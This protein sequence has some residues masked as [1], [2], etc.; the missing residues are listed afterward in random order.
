MH[1]VQLLNFISSIAW[2][3]AKTICPVGQACACIARDYSEC[4]PNPWTLI[5][6]IACP[7]ET[8]Q[9]SNANNGA[10][11]SA[12][13]QVNN[14]DSNQPPSQQDDSESS[15][16]DDVVCQYPSDVTPAP[17]TATAGLFGQC[18]GSCWIGPTRC[19]KGASCYTEQSPIS[20]AF[21]MCA[22]SPPSPAYKVRLAR[23]AIDVP[24]RVR[25]RATA[26]H[27]RPIH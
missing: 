11:L 7:P 14:G 8:T 5:T 1:Q 24:A 18:G 2:N 10:Q 21:A 17:S 15:P 3:G 12:D 13:G 22:P 9:N 20:G 16:S 23:E 25:A 4:I 6:P 26:I 27:F 19:P